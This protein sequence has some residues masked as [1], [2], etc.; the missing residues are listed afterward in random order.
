LTRHPRIVDIDDSVHSHRGAI[1]RAKV[2]MAGGP[3]H[4]RQ[5]LARGDLERVEFGDRNPAD[6]TRYRR[7]HGSAF[8]EHLAIG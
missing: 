3:R 6:S 4:G 8:P 5:Q 7:H 1:R 2:R